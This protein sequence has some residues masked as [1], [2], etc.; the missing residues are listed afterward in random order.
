MESFLTPI[1]EDS[2]E[3]FDTFDIDDEDIVIDI[4][5]S[6]AYVVSDMLD[7]PD[8]ISALDSADIFGSDEF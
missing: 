2:D 7:N 5:D 3:D 6:D 1:D 8:E 4:E